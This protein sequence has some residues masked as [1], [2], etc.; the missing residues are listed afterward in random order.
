MDANGPM[1]PLAG[2][3]DGTASRSSAG[4]AS[5]NMSV[6]TPGH[7]SFLASRTFTIDN[8]F[9]SSA[10]GADIAY[11][12]NMTLRMRLIFSNI[13]SNATVLL[14]D[15]AFLAV[16]D[17]GDGRP[18]L[19]AGDGPQQGGEGRL[20]VAGADI[21]D[22]GEQAAQRR[23]HLAGKDLV[24]QALGSP[25]FIAM[26]RPQGFQGTGRSLGG[27]GHIGARCRSN[28]TG[29]RIRDFRNDGVFH[30]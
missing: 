24:A 3:I 4:L 18:G 2:G 12:G 5:Y 21:V 15:S 27:M 8:P 26:S 14:P 7:F 13:A 29:R 28:R 25:D 16:G 10:T 30:G 11:D 23:A 1:L 9:T 6:T 17:A 19:A 22:E 20:A